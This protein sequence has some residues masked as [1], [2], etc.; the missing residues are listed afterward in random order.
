METYFIAANVDGSE[1]DAEIYGIGRSRGEA[2]KDSL[3]NDRRGVS[4]VV[5]VFEASE[6]L[7]NIVDANGGRNIDWLVQ[8]GVAILNPDSRAMVD[9]EAPPAE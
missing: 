7:F 2:L 5:S 8:D 3:A 4:T 9:G 1:D 6:E